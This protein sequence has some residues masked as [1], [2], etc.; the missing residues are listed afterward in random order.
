MR[1]RHGRITL[2]LMS[3][4][5]KFYLYIKV[6]NKYLWSYNLG[7]DFGYSRSSFVACLIFSFCTQFCCRVLLSSFVV[8][9]SE[10]PFAKYLLS[11]NDLHI[12]AVFVHLIHQL[13]YTFKRVRV[14][15]CLQSACLHIGK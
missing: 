8:E 5:L 6:F 2:V 11:F 9:L 15:V 14:C 7:Y 4:S 10:L 13:I 1:L 3:K 12:L